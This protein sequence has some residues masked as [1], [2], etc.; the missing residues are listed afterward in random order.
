MKKWDCLFYIFL[1]GIIGV[2]SGEMSLV[3]DEILSSCLIVVSGIFTFLTSYLMLKLYKVVNE[4]V[5]ENIYKQ[6]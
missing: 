4:Y 2:K 3:Q 6:E 1:F 5:E